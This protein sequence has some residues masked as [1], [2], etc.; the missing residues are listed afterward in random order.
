MH[1]RVNEPFYIMSLHVFSVL[2]REGGGHGN[3]APK[4]ILR[5]RIIAP[6]GLWQHYFIAGKHTAKMGKRKQQLLH[7]EDIS[8][9]CSLKAHLDQK[10]GTYL[11]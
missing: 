8:Y 3:T 5:I 6:K 11:G 2:P 7:A 10:A 1:C 9:F 4:E